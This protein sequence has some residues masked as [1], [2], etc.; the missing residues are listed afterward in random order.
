MTLRGEG[1]PPSPPPSRRPTRPPPLGVCGLQQPP[2][3]L[4]LRGRSSRLGK[5]RRPVQAPGSLGARVRRGDAGGLRLAGQGQ[6][7]AHKR[8]S[9]AWRGADA[10]TRGAAR[11]QRASPESQPS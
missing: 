6:R 3:W 11:G 7:T 10:L 9:G 4:R 8:D 5:P 2:G 1:K